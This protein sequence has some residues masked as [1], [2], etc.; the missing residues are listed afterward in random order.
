MSGQPFA[1]SHRGLVLRQAEE[2]DEAAVTQLINT[3]FGV[4]RFFLGAERLSTGEV[5]ARMERGR[6][7]LLEDSGALAGCVYA[8]L[9]GENGFIGLLSIHPQRQKSGLSRMLMSAAEEHFRQNGC[10]MAELRIVNL[11]TELAPYYRHLGY[12][13]TGIEQFPAEIPTILPC[14]LIVMTKG[15]R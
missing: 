14:H 6:F 7:F 11:R 3:A 9:R 10:G 13:E 8:E 12:C 2:R 1:E 4:E 5:R 15:L